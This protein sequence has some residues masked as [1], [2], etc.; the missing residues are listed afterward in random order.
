MRRNKEEESKTDIE[1]TT[2][3]VKKSLQNSFSDEYFEYSKNEEASF[4]CELISVEKSENNEKLTSIWEKDLISSSQE[5][6]GENSY[7]NIQTSRLSNNWT[8]LGN[9]DNTHLNIN[10][11]FLEQD[12]NRHILNNLLY[13]NY[14]TK[15]KSKFIL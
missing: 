9:M 12:H 7:E 13:G 2:F 6:E 14:K 11:S 10:S 1:N 5:D 8:P 4:D 15:V 3:I